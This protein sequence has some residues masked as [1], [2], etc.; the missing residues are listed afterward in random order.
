MGH[1]RHLL[2]VIIAV[3][4]L[5]TAHAQQ[6]NPVYVVSS[7]PAGSCVGSRVWVSN[8][9]PAVFSCCINGTW[10]ACGSSSQGSKGDTGATGPAG[11]RGPTGLTGPKGDTGL[12]GLTGATGAVGP[13]GATGPQGA[14]GIPGL[15]GLDGANGAK[16]DQG[17][18]GEQGVQGIGSYDGMS[19]GSGYY[20]HGFTTE[21]TVECS[22][23]Q[24]GGSGY[25]LPAA[26]AN[27]LGGVKGTGGSLT[28]SV[29]S[30][31]T[32]FDAAGALQCST[33]PAPANCATGY[34]ET[35]N[36]TTHSCTQTINVAGY[37]DE[38][39]TAEA[40]L[41]APS[42][43]T[44]GQASIGI[45]ADGSAD[46]CWTPQAAITWPTCGSGTF[47]KSAGAVPTCVAQSTVATDLNCT[48]CVA[49]LEI[50]A[51]GLAKISGWP[52]CG[53][54]T[55]L[56]SAGTTPTCVAQSTT[57]TDLACTTCV[58]DSEISAVGL[59]KV[60]GW[61]SCGT[62][63]FLKSASAAPTCVAGP[64]VPANCG[65]GYAETG[66]GST[67]SCIQVATPADVAAV[68]VRGQTC[69]SGFMNGIASNSQ[70]SCQTYSE[71]DPQVGSV[72]ASSGSNWC[73]SNGSAVQCNNPPPTLASIPGGLCG[74]NEIVVGIKTTGEPWCAS[75]SCSGC[76]IG[77]AH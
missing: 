6:G 39:G 22:Q 62:N 27:T 73:R 21:G 49:D 3:F 31:A 69:P 26:Q 57:A 33:P 70:I 72:T 35:G 67:H 77:G 59:S 4:A 1:L 76:S 65:T 41:N 12:R 54:N 53:T 15:D 71:T 7:P 44:A 23:D 20:V 68:D 28:C 11:A 37:A 32:G 29:L 36:G 25:S 16:G 17:E 61:P 46:G 64:A 60:S 9:N 55:F 38:A 14:P 13:T 50:S 5:S 51:V 8:S 10:T 47:L 2:A 30:W 52:T 74:Y 18:Q 45:L 75:F 42:K 48:T 66:N 63:T 58:A 40:F 56:K 34:V 43:C 19:C 24:S